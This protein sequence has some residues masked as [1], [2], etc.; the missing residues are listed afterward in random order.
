MGNDTRKL[1]PEIEDALRDLDIGPVSLILYRIDILLMCCTLTGLG[2]GTKVT[3][4]EKHDR[5]HS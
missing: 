3:I 5:G 4:S 2:F 1:V